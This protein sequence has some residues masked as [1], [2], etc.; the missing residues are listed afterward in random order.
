[1]TA[2]PDD[3][4]SYRSTTI[5]QP[6]FMDVPRGRAQHLGASQKAGPVLALVSISLEASAIGAE[7]ADQSFER[8][9]ACVSSNGLRL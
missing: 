9:P 3:A 5:Q 1:M 8:S 2:V 7:R 4:L 6:R